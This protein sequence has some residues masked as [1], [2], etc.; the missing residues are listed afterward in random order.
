VTEN[1]IDTA[2]DL[3]AGAT[4]RGDI[5]IMFPARQLTRA[6][7]PRHAAWLVALADPLGEEFPAVL[8]AVQSA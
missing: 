3:F 2:N 8:A 1:E 7:A 5:E 6:E 4:V